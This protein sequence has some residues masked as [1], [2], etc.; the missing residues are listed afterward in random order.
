MHFYQLVFV[1]LD[2]SRMNEHIFETLKIYENIFDAP[3]LLLNRGVH[4]WTRRGNILLYFNI[5][6]TRRV[7]F[8]RVQKYIELW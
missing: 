6:F 7:Y 1:I 5:I 2:A 3:T 8:R 4:F